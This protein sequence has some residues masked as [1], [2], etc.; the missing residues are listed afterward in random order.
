M[1]PNLP[2]STGTSPSLILSAA[3]TKHSPLLPFKH[4]SLAETPSL[5]GSLTAHRP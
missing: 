2:F 5:K 4:A 3:T 1:P